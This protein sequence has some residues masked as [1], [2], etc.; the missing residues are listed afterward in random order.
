MIY[1]PFRFVPSGIFGLNSCASPSSGDIPQLPRPVSNFQI[2][3]GP[4][5]KG[6]DGPGRL[7]RDFA[8]RPFEFRPEPVLWT[9][10]SAFCG[11][12]FSGFQYLVVINTRRLYGVCPA[13]KIPTGTGGGKKRD[14]VFGNI[15]G[16]YI[17]IFIPQLF[18]CFNDFF[19]G[20]FLLHG[21]PPKNFHVLTGMIC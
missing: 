1:R 15:A 17:H 4:P 5:N 9:I 11:A 14:V 21:R 7:I 3:A 6:L 16:R 20:P 12:L 19:F 8:I 10:W 13:G 2:H 18:N